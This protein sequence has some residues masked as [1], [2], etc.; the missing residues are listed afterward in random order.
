MKQPE[1]GAEHVQ[2]GLGLYVLGALS[3][4]ETIE[5][6]EHLAGCAPCRAE[7]DQLAEVSAFLALLTDEDAR[8]LVG[9]FGVPS[10]RPQ[11]AA[12]SRPRRIGLRARV[13]ASAA[14]AVLVTMVGLGL[15]LWG[16]YD[17]APMVTTAGATDSVTGAS[18]S[19]IVSGRD[20]G[21]DVR[22]VVVGLQPGV[23]FHLSALTSDG[24]SHEVYRGEAA[25]GPQTV[26][27]DVDVSPQEITFFV[28]ARL[29]GA[30]VVSVQFAARFSRAVKV[31]AAAAETLGIG[32][33]RGAPADHRTYAT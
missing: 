17:P 2:L 31:T 19:V 10:K 1:G 4:A 22:A 15:W 7:R 6:E 16:T 32:A 9:E 3:L 20:D 27:G 23:A 28:V 12:P 14:A 13:A 21:V 26:V 30:V 18:L 29:D 8:A 11:P 25:G 33:P 24:R 5:I